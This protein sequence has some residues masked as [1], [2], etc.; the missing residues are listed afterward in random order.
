MAPEIMTRDEVEYGSEVDIYRFNRD[1]V[2]LFSFA[3]LSVVDS[4]I[5]SFGLT[6]WVI[7]SEEH[8]DPF[9]ELDVITFVFDVCLMCC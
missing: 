3:I 7:V 5:P 2:T 8:R 1:R 6:M 4:D 9:A